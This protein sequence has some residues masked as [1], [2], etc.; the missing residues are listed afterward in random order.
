MSSMKTI[1]FFLICGLVLIVGL[2]VTSTS[3]EA[4]RTAKIAF[5]SN[6][7]GNS[8]IYVMNP[9]GSEQVNLTHHPGNDYSPVWSPTGKQ[10]LFASDRGGR[11]SDL[12]MMNADG[13][14]VR[15]VFNRRVARSHPTWSPDGEQIAYYRV[16][17]GEVAIYIAS[18]D[19]GAE[20]R[21]ATGMHPAWAPDGSE[22]AFMSAK[23]LIPIDEFGGI[24]IGNPRIEIIDL[25]TDAEDQI[26]PEGF[27][28]LFNPT[29][30]PDGTQLVFSG[31]SA[32]ER[33][34]PGP[35]HAMSLYIVNRNGKG[36]PRRIEVKGSV[37]NPALA[38]Q[39]N[40]LVYDQKTNKGRQIFKT[41]LAGDKSEQLTERGGNYGADWFD[42]AFALPVS[43]QPHL[44]TTVWGEMKVRD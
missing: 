32:K 30:T 15:R 27:P 9:D 35:V 36:K 18:I 42:P 40:T 39:G 22:I 19:G 14:G 5:A 34:G 25:R 4:L 7:D 29:W 26:S 1:R 3:V 17:R 20:K 44:L 2:S 28:L 41:T 31:L 21:I 13:G 23:I 8:E 33:V 37:S 10:I 6:R 38:P 24:E 12:Y 11:T 16:D 43:P